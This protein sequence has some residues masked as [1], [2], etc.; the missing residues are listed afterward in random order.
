[1]MNFLAG[2]GALGALGWIG[3]LALPDDLKVGQWR[4]LTAGDLAAISS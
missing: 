2:G 4:W 1:M 3:A